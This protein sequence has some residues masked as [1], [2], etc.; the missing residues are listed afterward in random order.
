MLLDFQIILYIYIHRIGHT[1]FPVKRFVTQEVFLDQLKRTVGGQ[2]GSENKY[3]EK[4]EKIP[5]A[6]FKTQIEA[7]LI[8]RLKKHQEYII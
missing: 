2:T 5:A 6:L 3:F 8:I 7:F 1:C 4:E